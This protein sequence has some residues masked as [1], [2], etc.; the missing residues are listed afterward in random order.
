M[1]FCFKVGL[2][3]LSLATALSACSGQ[4]CGR[5]DWC[6]CSGG[7]ECLQGC[8]D[9]D[10]CRFFCSLSD[11][12]TATCGTGCTFDFHDAKENSFSCG[13][14]CNIGCHESTACGAI[15]GA[16]CD[17]TAYNVVHSGARVGPNSMVSCTD[18][19]VCVVECL[20][21]CTVA[22]DQVDTCEVHC[23][24]NAAPMSCQNGS[25]ACGACR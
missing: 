1:K 7:T 24:N 25:L 18:V 21:S 23:P 6:A 4:K 5:N 14:A 17:Y 16:N 20:G 22:C 19:K 2:V 11:R 9:V 8:D 15:C 10:G 12:C 13:D 3:L